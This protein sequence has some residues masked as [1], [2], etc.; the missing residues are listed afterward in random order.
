MSYDDWKLDSPPERTLQ[1][2]F[3][4][5]VPKSNGI[6][7]WQ[8]FCLMNDQENAPDWAWEACKKGPFTS[9][10]GRCIFAIH[11]TLAR[12]AGYPEPLLVASKKA[13]HYVDPRYFDACDEIENVWQMDFSFYSLR[14]MAEND[15]SI[16]LYAFNFASL[17]DE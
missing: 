7:N 16:N 12:L 1:E 6:L 10:I 11:V 9:L 4:R 3:R 15:Y 8:V 13:I 5:E 14:P 2:P 17:E